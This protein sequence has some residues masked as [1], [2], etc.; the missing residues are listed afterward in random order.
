MYPK[1][2]VNLG[3]TRHP[4]PK[5]CCTKY[6]DLMISFQ[7]ISYMKC[8]K[9]SLYDSDLGKFIHLIHCHILLTSLAFPFRSFFSSIT[10]SFYALAQITTTTT[11]ITISTTTSKMAKD[12]KNNNNNRKDKDEDED[13]QR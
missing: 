13:E 6:S 11:A 9:L 4:P 2:R 3:A 7:L 5:F 10:E 12:N 8:D 1:Y